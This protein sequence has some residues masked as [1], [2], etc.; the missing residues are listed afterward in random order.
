MGRTKRG[1]SP[2]GAEQGRI[3][4]LTKR[5]SRTVQESLVAEM[6]E[7]VGFGFREQWLLRTAGEALV[8]DFLVEGR[9]LVECTQSTHRNCSRAWTVLWQRAIYLDYKFR[10]AKEAGSF[11]T[12]T[13]LEVSHCGHYQKRVLTQ[14]R[15]ATLTH[16]NYLV[17]TIPALGEHLIGVLNSETGDP[18]PSWQAESLSRWL[19]PEPDKE[20]NP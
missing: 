17:T 11:T 1:T 13:L 15:L 8:F 7:A 18:V 2:S 9:V 5:E 16:T 19:N 10:L 4:C 3:A 14:E 20:E 6:M 12:M